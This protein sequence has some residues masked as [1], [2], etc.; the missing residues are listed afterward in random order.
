MLVGVID[1]LSL[2]LGLTEIRI[3]MNLFLVPCLS[4]AILA[5]ET[6]LRMVTRSTILIG[7]LVL[8]VRNF[9]LV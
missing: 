5:Q 1:L 9:L 8:V 6:T 3:V 4:T 2:V 7:L